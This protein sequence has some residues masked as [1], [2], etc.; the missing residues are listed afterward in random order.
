MMMMMTTMMITVTSACR[1][2]RRRR[3]SW[4]LMIIAEFLS[5]TSTQV[6]SPVL[7]CRVS[8]GSLSVPSWKSY[9]DSTFAPHSASG[10]PTWD[11][12][13]HGQ[14]HF[15]CSWLKLQHVSHFVYSEYSVFEDRLLQ[16]IHI[17]NY[18]AHRWIPWTFII[19]SRGYRFLNLENH[20][21][22]HVLPI[23]YFPKATFSAPK[24]SVVLSE[25]IK[26][27]QYT[28]H[29]VFYLWPNMFHFTI[30]IQGP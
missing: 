9:Y 21:R 6:P 26:P 29:T 14:T 13:L 1:M 2:K 11:N 3:L 18:F 16:L 23:F 4:A 24:V 28:C 27:T 5:L 19:F 30:H 15:E 25:I 22:I 20:W 8:S 17:F 10:A 12:P 7:L